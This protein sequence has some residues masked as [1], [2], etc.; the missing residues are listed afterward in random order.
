VSPLTSVEGAVALVTGG[1]R[2]LG[3]AYVDAL[4]RHG[5]V[6]IYAAARK[7]ASSEDPRVAAETLE[8]TDPEPV[9]SLAERT[10]DVSIVVNSAGVLIPGPLSKSTTDD[11][12][13]PSAPTSSAPCMWRR[14]TRRSWPATA[15]ERW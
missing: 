14:P 10:D 4:E 2:G 12:P 5:A 13:R 3:G 15:A 7:P 6:K 1:R 11:V 9:R 8:V